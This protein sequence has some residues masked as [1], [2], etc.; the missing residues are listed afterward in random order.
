MNFNR[1]FKPIFLLLILCVLPDYSYSQIDPKIFKNMRARSIGPAGT[2]GRI[3]AI[4]AVNSN[5][6]IIYIGGAT[7]GLWK[8]VNG[9]LSFKSVFDKQPVA[10]IGAIAIYQKNHSI[11]WVGTGEANPRNRRPRYTLI[12]NGRIHKYRDW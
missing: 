11:I 12:G 6:N 8:S 5:P 1:I 10:S 4:E 9:G 7:G 3:G 2:S